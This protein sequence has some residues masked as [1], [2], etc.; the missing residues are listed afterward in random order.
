[1]DHVIDIV[2]HSITRIRSHG[3]DHRKF[4]ALFSELDAQYGSLSCSMGRKWLSRG[5]VLR[6]FFELLEEIDFFHVF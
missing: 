1:M 6:R 2:I 3:S 5:M 4:S